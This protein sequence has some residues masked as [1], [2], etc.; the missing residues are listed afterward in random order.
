MTYQLMATMA[1]GLEA[2]TAKELQQLG[3]ETTTENGRVLFKG[4]LKDVVRTNLW[5]RS[6]DRIKI[7]LA[8]FKALSFEDLFQG[9]KAVPLEEYLPM[10]AQFPVTGR[11]VRSKLHSEPDIQGVTKKAMVER[12]ASFY[13]RRTRFPETG[14]R[15]LFDINITKDKARFT[16]DTTGDSLFKRGYRVEAGGAPIKENFAAALI[17]L[18]NWHTDM[19][20]SD[21]MCGSGTIPIEAALI[22]HNIAPGRLRKFAFEA[23]DWFDGQ[24]LS[25]AK[26]QAETMIRQD[27]LTIYGSDI[28]Q[29]MIQIAKVNAS[30]AGVLHDIQFKQIAVK[31]LNID[32]DDGVLVTNPPYGKRL[33][34]AESARELYK[35]LGQV[36]RPLKTWSKYILTSDLEFEHYFGAKATKRRKLYNGALRADYFQY[37][38]QK[39]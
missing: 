10:N 36:F 4:D 3:Y 39:H 14:A 8:E 22:G 24:L 26:A 5:L 37:W 13:H 30:N 12:L 32:E 2:I 9:I 21:P 19:P 11:S 28:D 17:L 35:E 27:P 16:L 38:A 23:F 25:D 1:S 33:K 29:N 7:I 34:D 18:T 31:D 15:Y 6:A 20:F